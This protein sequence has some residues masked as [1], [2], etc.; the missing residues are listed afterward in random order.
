[1]SSPCCA[2][3]AGYSSGWCEESFGIPLCASEILCRARGDAV[4]RFMMAHPNQIKSKIYEYSKKHPDLHIHIDNDLP[5]FFKRKKTEEKQQNKC[6]SDLREKHSALKTEREQ[7]VKLLHNIL[8]AAVVEKMKNGSETISQ[9]HES[10]TILFADVVDFTKTISDMDSEVLISWLNRLFTRID[11]LTD[12]YQLEKIKTIGDAYMLAGGVPCF[13]PD[14]VE[15]VLNFSLELVELLPTMLDPKGHQVE[16]RIGVCTGGP[17]CSG[18]I[19]QKKFLFD[20]W[21]DTVNLASRMQTLG[22]PGKIH[23]TESVKEAVK[24]KFNFAERGYIYVKGKGYLRTFYCT[25]RKAP[26]PHL[27]KDPTS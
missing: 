15:A 12:K 7:V 11:K 13:R 20:V 26:T 27:E 17:V 16:M 14:H 1:M 19:G 2:M 8:P 21:G 18:V 3:N 23:C 9:K 22:E 4:C 6:L 10:V 5:G 24:H 25:G